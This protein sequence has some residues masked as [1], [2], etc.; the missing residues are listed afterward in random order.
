M[1]HYMK[2]KTIP[3]LFARFF[4]GISSGMFM[5]ALPWIMLAEQGM[6][7]FVAVTALVCTSLSFV[8]TPLFATLIDRHSRKKI[9][10]YM[11]VF[12]VTMALIV[13]IAYYHHI[14]SHWLLAFA[15]LIF[16]LT[17]DFAWSCNN[18]F[19]QEN[20][21]QDEYAKISS[22]Q[23]VVM[24]VTTLGAGALG[25]ILLEHWT[26]LEFA[27]LA[28]IA[29]LLSCFAYVATPY[30]RQFKPAIK[31][32]FLKQLVAS[33]SIFAKQL[34]FYGF[35]A[36]S[37][38]SYPVL[39]FM[40][41]LIP[42]YFSEQGISGSW[43]A[44]WKISYGIGALLTGLVIA[45]LLNRY[46]HEN[47]MIISMFVM[48]GSLVVMGFYL[49]PIVIILLTVVI[50]FFSSYNRIART[51]KMHH[52]IAMEE[53]GRVDGGLKLFSTL[54]QSLS[55]VVIALL[56]YLQITE[57]GFMIVGIVLLVA[58]LTMINLKQSSCQQP[59]IR[60]GA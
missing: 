41:K 2:N 4:D 37:C 55:Y 54:S 50:G 12:Q 6:G 52:V 21:H 14:Q 59:L 5:M 58:A 40:V 29:S 23:E 19:T 8:I 20:Y 1:D 35:L 56:S 34:H 25:I 28:A 53:R 42:I 31:E 39:T 16:W 32:T 17:N 18:A 49:S 3:Y 13:F 46:S 44:S 15:Q 27:L 45:R 24:Q 11:Q 36:L 26:M 22:Y 10:I 60:Q 38:L 57:L 47:A 48:G 9:L 43:F 33:K 51:N 30:V 7:T